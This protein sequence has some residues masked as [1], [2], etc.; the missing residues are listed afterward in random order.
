MGPFS[1]DPRGAVHDVRRR[2]QGARG[3]TEPYSTEREF[4]DIA[5]VVRSVPG[6]VNLLGHSY[7]A[8]ICLEAALRVGNLRRLVLYEPGFPVTEPLYPPG[9]R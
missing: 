4:E 8:L 9:L 5:A 7:G 3:D 2:L 1:P 6:A